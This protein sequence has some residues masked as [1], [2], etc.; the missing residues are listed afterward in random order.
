M[1][2]NPTKFLMLVEGLLTETVGDWVARASIDRG[3]GLQYNG[4]T[5]N[6][7]LVYLS[8]FLYLN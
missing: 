6:Y 4:A 8:T 1:L 5:L 7:F 3:G 2:S